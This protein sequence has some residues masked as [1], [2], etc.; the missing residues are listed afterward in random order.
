MTIHFNRHA[1]RDKR[2]F[3]RNNPTPAEKQLWKF[4]QNRKVLGYKF[5]RQYGI[6]SY[7]VD[8]YCPKLKLAIEI[9][10]EIHQWEMMKL[11]DAMR[12]E[13]IEQ[14]KIVFL[15]FTNAAVLKEIKKVISTIEDEIKNLRDKN[16]IG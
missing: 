3:L 15:R 1:D 6:D 10:G 16:V 13:Y 5:R 9:D 11:S 8:F 14:F 7:V 2:R 12:Q 4:L